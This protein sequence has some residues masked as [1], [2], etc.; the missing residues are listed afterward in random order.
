MIKERRPFSAILKSLEGTLRILFRETNSSLS[1]EFD[2]MLEP[3]IIYTSQLSFSEFENLIR[4]E[5]KKKGLQEVFIDEKVLDKEDESLS[6]LDG[7][8]AWTSLMINLC[9]ELCII[10]T[11]DSMPSPVYAKI[12]T[13]R[14]EWAREKRKYIAEEKGK[15]IRLIDALNREREEAKQGY[16]ET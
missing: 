2:L 15:I 10:F 3:Y 6:S 4:E 8:S 11:I 1:D 7:D 13:L 5:N 14:E 16:A 12:A 9:G